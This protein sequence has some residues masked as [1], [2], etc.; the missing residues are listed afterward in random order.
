MDKSTEEII[1]TLVIEDKGIIFNE[2]I[3]GKQQIRY[4]KIE[5]NY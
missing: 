2:W 4:T 3:E 1:D 5:Q